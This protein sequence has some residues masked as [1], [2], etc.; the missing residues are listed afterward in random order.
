MVS[1]VVAFAAGG[2]EAEAEI[3]LAVVPKDPETF[4][5]DMLW[6]FCKRELPAYMRPRAIW[7]L[8]EIPLTSSGKPDRV[9]LQRS[10]DEQR[11]RS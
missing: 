2:T 8:E 4:R 5:E 9:A 1:G 6:D 3:V 10:Y 7:R 11:A